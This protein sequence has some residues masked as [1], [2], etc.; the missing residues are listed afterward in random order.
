MM[1]APNSCTDPARIGPCTASRISARN[2]HVR[3]GRAETVRRNPIENSALQQHPC[4][5]AVF[6]KAPCTARTHLP[7]M[8]ECS[9]HGSQQCGCFGREKISLRRLGSLTNP[10]RARFQISSGS[11][12]VR[13]AA[14][15]APSL[16]GPNFSSLAQSRSLRLGRRS[17]ADP[18]R[19]QR[20][21]SFGPRAYS[22]RRLAASVHSGARIYGSLLIPRR[23]PTS[24]APLW[25]GQQLKA[26][27]WPADKLS[28]AGTSLHHTT[29]N[30]SLP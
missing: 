5:R 25:L 19:G 26:R 7:P 4:S 2:L 23:T 8:G 13:S 9:V 20:R 18:P 3:A 24:R 30:R 28:V 22:R 12:A 6:E 11:G 10:S 1:T 14:P 15:S 29:S 17:P 21:Y 27:P 16:E